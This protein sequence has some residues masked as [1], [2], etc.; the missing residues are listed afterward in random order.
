MKRPLT[1][2]ADSFRQRF[3]PRKPGSRWSLVNIRHARRL[4]AEGRTHASGLAAFRARDPQEARNYSFE[5]RSAA[6]DTALERKFRADRTAWANFEAR[7]PGYRRLHVHW[8]MS[9]KRPETRVLRL[10]RLIEASRDRRDVRVLK[11][12]PR[13]GSRRRKS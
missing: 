8:V 12:A 4:E 5:A 11:R 13:P 1:P 10:E 6:F 2:T 9:A 7:P 3:S